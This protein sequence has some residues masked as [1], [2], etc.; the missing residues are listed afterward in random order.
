MSTPVLEAYFSDTTARHSAHYHDCHQL[1]FITRGSAE[2][3][4]DD[5]VYTAGEGC[6]VIFSRFENHAVR[7]LTPVY[8]RYVLR[9]RPNGD[10]RLYSLLAN[11]PQGFRHIVDTGGHAAELRALFDGIVREA[12]SR[13]VLAD[14]LSRLLTD[15]LMIRLYRCM[16]SLPTPEDRSDVVFSL[17]RRFE[18]EPQTAYAL[19]NLAR[20]YGMSVSS[21]S[22][23]FKQ[24]TGTS[25]MGYLLSCR[26]AAAKNLLTHTALGIGE[27]V[28]RCG[29]SDSSNFSRTFKRAT[30]LSPTVFR[31]QYSI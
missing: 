30:G 4:V 17:Q 29:F 9:I 21:L 6:V 27:I 26:L 7:I 11:R 28:E 1:L 20:E 19:E 14:E 16:P 24:V 22:H 25:V 31:R 3:R 10:S 18:S 8:E 12:A 15:E 23:R 2:I 13:E 5:A